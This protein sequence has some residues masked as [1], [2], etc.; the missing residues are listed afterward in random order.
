MI[1][2][3]INFD[4]IQFNRPEK[5]SKNMFGSLFHMLLRLSPLIMIMGI[6]AEPN[7]DRRITKRITCWNFSIYITKSMSPYKGEQTF[8][9]KYSW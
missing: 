7:I 8:S 4:I 6:F 3:L 9:F 5:K 2:R 1:I